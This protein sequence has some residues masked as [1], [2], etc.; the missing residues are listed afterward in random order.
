MAALMHPVATNLGIEP[1]R[2][3]SW[4]LD[5]FQSAVRPMYGWPTS[6]GPNA[7][8]SYT[9]MNEN[10]DQ[11][12]ALDEEYLRTSTVGELT[13]LA[14]QIVLVE[15]DPQWPHRFQNE[16]KRIRTVLG[17]HALRI[18]HVGSTSVPG[19]SAKPII[20]IV[21]VVIDSANELAYA[22]ALEKAGYQLRIRE[23]GWYEHRMFKS[24]E[25]DVNLHL[26]S[27]DCPEIDRMVTF[28]DWLRTS[29]EDRE[30][31]ARS[32]TTLA[33]KHWKYT[34][35]YADAKTAV[36]ERIML[37]ARRAAR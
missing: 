24:A 15:Y 2:R 17:E 16:A 26:F 13:P 3:A 18:E 22:P 29:A 11:R 7:T 32:K 23:P 1:E 20:D 36:V 27:A 5:G 31:Y 33:Q 12:R 10:C 21:L 6:R 8:I 30:L 37:R 34:Q 4:T 35:N 14:G 28:R 25:G 9:H 19:L